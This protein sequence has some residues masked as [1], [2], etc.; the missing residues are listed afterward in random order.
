[1]EVVGDQGQ[2]GEGGEIGEERRERARE[3]VAAKCESS[4]FKQKAEL[5]GYSP[6]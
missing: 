1:M 2:A 6:L 3:A 5:G 4:Q